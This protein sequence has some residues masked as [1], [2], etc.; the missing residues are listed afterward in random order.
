MS[1]DIR[2]QSEHKPSDRVEV[3]ER[4]A[5]ETRRGR[6]RHRVHAPELRQGALPREVRP[7]A[8][9]PAPARRRRG[10]GR[11]RRVHLQAGGVLPQPRRPADR[12]RVA[13]PRRVHQGPQRPRR[14]RHEDPEGVRRPRP[15]D[16]ALR[17]RADAR[18]IGAPVDRRAR[19]GAQVHRRARA[20]Q[21]V[22]HR[23]AE[24]GVPHPLRRRRGHGLPAHRARRRLRPGPHGLDR[25]A[26][27]RRQGVHPRRGQALDHQRRHRRA[28][29]RDGHGAEARGRPWRHLGL[30]R[31]DRRHQASR[32]RT[33]TSSWG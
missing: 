29:R 26:Q 11:G 7:A 32:S 24:A 4:E 28:G 12:A 15:V 14:L 10:G 8:D 20:G 25:Q 3:S 31:R 5:R 16:A 22:R 23:R 6:P 9:P 13:D 19:V 33:A 27:R 2:P 17:P 30:R 21:D 18:R 1:T